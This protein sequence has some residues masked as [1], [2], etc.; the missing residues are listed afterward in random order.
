MTR[1]RNIAYGV[2]LLLGL[3]VGFGLLASASIGFFVLIAMVVAVV[4]VLAHGEY[5]RWE[6]AAGFLLALGASVLYIGAYYLGASWV[7][8][9]TVLLVA[10]VVWTLVLLARRGERGVPTGVS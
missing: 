7:T 9:G 2:G 8:T 3:G 10:G 6:T 1:T 5:A 4:L